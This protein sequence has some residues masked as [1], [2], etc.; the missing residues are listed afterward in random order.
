[1]P[2]VRDDDLVRVEL[3]T[4]GEWVEVR[5]Q[6]SAGELRRLAGVATAARPL[7]DGNVTIQEAAGL[8]D[9]LGFAGLEIGIRRWSFEAEVTPENIRRLSQDDYELVSERCDDLWKTRSSDEKNG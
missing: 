6:L 1:M 5:R 9:S 3:S 4:P 7:V 2:L 8:M